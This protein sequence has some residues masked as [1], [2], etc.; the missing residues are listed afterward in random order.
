MTYITELMSS[1]E[2]TIVF[3]LF[4]AVIFGGYIGAE[5]IRKKRP[6]GIK[7]HAVVALGA[8]LAMATNEYIM[9]KISPGTDVSRFAA[10]V[11]SGIGF[12]GAGMIMIT[13][14]NQ[15]TGLTTAAGLW[16]AACI[17]IAVGIGFYVGAIA[18]MILL[19]FIKN[20]FG[21]IDRAIQL[22]SKVMNL[23]V[24][25]ISLEVINSV[26]KAILEAG[27]NIISS[28]AHKH[29]SVTGVDGAIPL[30]MSIYMAKNVTHQDLM[31]K[32]IGLDGVIAAEEI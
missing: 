20:V 21:R 27:C 29:E 30:Q 25:C 2:F 15:V 1:Y 13:G 19:G 23:I 8:A 12:L 11:I 24:D 14:R 22:N 5:R 4:L 6:A 10:Q 9:L 17:G 18:A 28:S 7:T 31:G 3:R 16:V 32:I 26:N